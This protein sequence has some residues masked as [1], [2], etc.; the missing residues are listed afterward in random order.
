MAVMIIQSKKWTLHRKAEEGNPRTK[1]VRGKR[2][3]KS[4][5]GSN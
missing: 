3:G 1:S 2:I 5:D 4:D